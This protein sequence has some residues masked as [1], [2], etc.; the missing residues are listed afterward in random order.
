L[1]DVTAWPSDELDPEKPASVL[2]A[3]KPRMPAIAVSSFGMM[4]KAP[5]ENSA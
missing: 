1:F 2:S 3:T 4:S 5:S